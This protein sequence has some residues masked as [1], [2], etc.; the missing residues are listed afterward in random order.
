[1]EKDVV[2]AGV[3]MMGEVKGTAE[4]IKLPVESLS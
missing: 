4:S 1:M 2:C 3:N